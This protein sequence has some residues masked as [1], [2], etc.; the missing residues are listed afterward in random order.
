V[1]PLVQVEG[2]SVDYRFG[3]AW[4][5]AVEDVSFEIRRGEVFGLVGESGCGKS[6]LAYQL[7]GYRHPNARVRAGRVLFADRDLLTLGRAGLEGLRGDRISFVA[8][9]PTTAL[10]P[11]MRVGRQVAE[12]L[13]RHGK[14]QGRAA[15]AAR[16]DA[17]FQQVGLPASEAL[18]RRYPH[19]LSGGQQQRVV[20]AMALACE[21]D[22]VVL[23]EPTTGLD[24]TTQRQIIDLLQDLRQRFRM[25]MVY[26]THDLL[27]LQEIADRIGVMYAGHL[28]ET[29]PTATLFGEPAHPYT[30]GLIG[31]IPQLDSRRL[32]RGRSLRGLLRRR[33]LPP[34][35]PLFPRCDFAEPSCAERRQVLEPIGADHAVACQNWRRAAAAPSPPS[36]DPGGPDGVAGEPLLR[37]DGVSLGYGFGRTGLLSRL[38]GDRGVVVAEDVSLQIRSGEVLALIGESGSGKSTIARAICGLI[39]PQAGTMEFLGAPLRGLVRQRSAEQRRAIQYVFQNPDASLNPRM[40]VGDIVTRPID[41]F[42]GRRGRR[43]RDEVERAL[44]EVRLDASYVARFPDQLSGGERQRVAIARALAARP[45]LLLCDEVLSAL[46]VSVQ[47]RVLL[48]LRQLRRETGVAML[49]ISHDLT[50]VRSLAD[51]VGVLYR[52]ALVEEGPVEDIFSPPYHPYTR[53]LLLAVPG[54]QRRSRAALSRRVAERATSARVGCVF[55]GRCPVQI[56]GLCASA[57]PPWRAAGNGLKIRCHLPLPDLDSPVTL[58]A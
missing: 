8:Q 35:C 2:L 27:L 51:R 1:T 16:V 56:E 30:A 22:L 43:A 36:V 47:A 44:L 4:L 20:I 41:V 31:S 49:F 38:L 58:S 7:L 15:I 21:P 45:T 25:S 17:L 28:V 9:N 18:R 57:P 37:V 39:A 33:D 46:D 26:V 40:R 34:G 23:D 14:A 48:L 32:G 13:A 50:V 42:F 5:A 52:G 11:G 54:G 53:N 10:S 12:L 24:V 55:T 6:T 29:G 3:D 19:E